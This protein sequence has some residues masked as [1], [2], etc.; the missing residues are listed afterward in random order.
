LGTT[1]YVP[2]EDGD[3]IQSPKHCVLIKTGRWMMSRN[4]KVVLIYHYQKLLDLKFY[5]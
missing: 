3:R 4:T 2:P 1:E 5:V